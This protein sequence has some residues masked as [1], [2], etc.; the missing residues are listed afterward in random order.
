MKLLLVLLP[1]LLT[2]ISYSQKIDQYDLTSEL[3]VNP[4]GLETYRPLLSLKT[5]KYNTYHKATTKAHNSKEREKSKL[6]E[7]EYG[8]SEYNYNSLAV[9]RGKSASEK[10]VKLMNSLAEK[11]KNPLLKRHFESVALFT[12]D[13]THGFDITEQNIE[14]ASKVLDFFKDDGSKLATYIEGPRPLMMSFKSHTDGKFSYY[15]LIL[16]KGFNENKDDYSLYLELHGSS[17]GKN[18]NPRRLLYQPLQPEVQGVT[19]QGYRKEGLFVRPWG[20]GDKR[21]LEIAET[22][23]FEVLADFDKVFKT[24]R[25]SQ[26]LY[27]VMTFADVP[28]WM[29]WG[30]EERFAEV[31]RKLKDLFLEANVELKWT[32]IEGVGHKYLSEYQEEM[33]DWFKNK[34]K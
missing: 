20:R 26:Y 31:N 2:N 27:G 17:G 34:T 29:A 3:K 8:R 14:E 33:M 11:E 30:E 5:E 15:W 12:M 32:E 10:L 13:T 18:D 4:I 23:I 25:K 21:Y 1:L 22:D 9:K 7:I 6:L 28:V 16:P 19:S 24:D